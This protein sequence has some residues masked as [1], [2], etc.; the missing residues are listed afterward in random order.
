MVGRVL[1]SCVMSSLLL[2]GCA[3]LVHAGGDDWMSRIEESTPVSRITVPGTHNS[4][5]LIGGNMAQ[6]QSNSIAKQLGYGIRFLDIRCYHTK[7]RFHIYHGIINQKLTFSSVLADIYAFLDANPSETVMVSI[8]EEN[9]KTGQPA[10]GNTLNQYIAQR[11]DKWWTG[12]S[13][14]PLKEV[15]GKI[16]LIRRFS[17]DQAIGVDAMNWKNNASFKV[18]NL[19]VQ[20]KYEVTGNV[21][22]WDAV[23]AALA[24]AVAEPSPKVAYFNYTSGYKAGFLGIPDIR[25]VSNFI[26]PKLERYFDR[27][28]PGHYGCV[29]MDFSSASLSQ[30]IYQAN[31]FI[32]SPKVGR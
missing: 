28:T 2:T 24:A 7:G 16:M 3:A 18:K 30:K 6:C 5:A 13:M 14:P 11:P 19:R 15:R 27:V 17:S 22:K 4:G 29:I 31:V 26:N 23:K 20:D 21:A 1:N 10:F 9:S 25:S 12:N 8:K 32:K